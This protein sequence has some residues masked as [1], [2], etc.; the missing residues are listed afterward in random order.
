MQRGDS[1]LALSVAVNTDLVTLANGNCIT[2]D[3]RLQTDSVI[4]V[5][6]SPTSTVNNLLRVNCDDPSVQIISPTPLEQISGQRSV[7]GLMPTRDFISYRLDV[8][9][10]ESGLILSTLES[11]FQPI[12]YGIIGTLDTTR[13]PLGV[14]RLRLNVERV[15]TTTTCDIPVLLD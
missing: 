8:V 7:I 3:T 11:S 14:V 12:T 1:L 10:V 2:V 5:P 9:D 6:R 13:L 15:T 4:Y